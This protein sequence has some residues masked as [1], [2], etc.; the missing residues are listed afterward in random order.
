MME[1]DKEEFLE[2]KLGYILGTMIQI[3]DEE[4]S[5]QGTLVIH[6]LKEPGEGF[7]F[8]IS[9][10]KIPKKKNLL[11]RMKEWMTSDNIKI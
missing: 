10:E 11:R 9:A 2:L 7:E 5:D 1:V 3:M 4:N 6:M 8:N